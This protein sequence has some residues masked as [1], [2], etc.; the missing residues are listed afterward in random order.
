MIW[1]SYIFYLPCRYACYRYV[2]F[3]KILVHHTSR[4][5][6]DAVAQ[7]DAA[8]YLR[9]GTNP[10]VVADAGSA[11]VS[12]GTDV[13]SLVYVTE[14]AYSCI[15][16]DYYQSEMVDAQTFTE[17]VYGNLYSKTNAKPIVHK[18]PKEF[19]YLVNPPPPQPITA[20]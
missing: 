14:F 18:A 17:Y 4:T 12:I 2:V 10:A 19:L 20:L 6:H 1:F 5:Y 8:E 11:A 13:H 7:A 3:P 16:V 15:R 9:A